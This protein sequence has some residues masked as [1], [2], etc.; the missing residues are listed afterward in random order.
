MF[1]NTVKI[2]I[3]CN[4]KGFKYL[5]HGFVQFQGPSMLAMIF[6]YFRKQREIEYLERVS[7][8]IKNSQIRVVFVMY[9][10]KR[11]ILK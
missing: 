8:M 3:M 2:E 11:Q 4:F 5:L 1:R 7:E 6:I 10:C 9:E